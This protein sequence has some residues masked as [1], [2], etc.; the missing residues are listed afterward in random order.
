MLMTP[1]FL[2]PTWASPRTPLYIQLLVQS[3]VIYLIGIS[4]LACPNMSSWYCIPFAACHLLLLQS[5]H[6]ANGNSSLLVARVKMLDSC[7]IP[8]CLVWFGFPSPP[9]LPSPSL[10]HPH[11]SQQQTLTILS[12]FIAWRFLAPPLLPT[13]SV[14]YHIQSGFFQ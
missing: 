14:C 8:F 1:P 11:P 2:S 5:S 9:L 3:P 12:I 4:N 13:D 6:T 10:P 7:L